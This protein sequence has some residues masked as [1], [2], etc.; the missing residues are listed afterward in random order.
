MSAPGPAVVPI[1]PRPS[2]FPSS[3]PSNTAY[4]GGKDVND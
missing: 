2:P 1:A 4:G 3:A